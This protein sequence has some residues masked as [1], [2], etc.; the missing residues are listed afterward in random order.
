MVSGLV[1]SLS[2]AARREL[3]ERTSPLYREASLA[4]KGLLLD[5][6]VAVTGYARKYAIRLLNQIP[7]CQYTI[8]RRRECLACSHRWFRYHSPW[9]SQRIFRFLYGA[10][11]RRTAD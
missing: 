4:Q 5:R 2:Y 11:G 9:P 1:P 6:T 8:R 10:A 3:I 7:Q